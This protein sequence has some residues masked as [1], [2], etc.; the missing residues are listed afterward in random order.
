[1]LNTCMEKY[2]EDV[3]VVV[4]LLTGGILCRAHSISNAHAVSLGFVN[5][6]PAVLPVSIPWNVTHVNET[7]DFDD[8]TQN[9]QY[10]KNVFIV[11]LPEH[12]ITHEWIERRKLAR[13]R[14]DALWSWE[15]CCNKYL[16]ERSLDYYFPGMMDAYLAEQLQ[17]CD[18]KT[19]H[20]A[21]AIIE[22]ATISQVEPDIA[23][24]EL[25]L[26]YEGLGLRLVRNHAL[27]FRYVRI[28][29]SID[30]PH[31]LQDVVIKAT[32]HLFLSKIPNLESN[33]DD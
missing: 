27:Y 6:I 10:Q 22:W 12:L 11:P 9:Y 8:L 33:P 18:P 17:A 4:D 31:M 19:G 26:R 13:A 1:M 25:K 32:Q 5:A 15:V 2:K 29:N 20:Y 23:Y 3:C 14:A 21:P 28:I 24:Q 16:S 30:I 7:T